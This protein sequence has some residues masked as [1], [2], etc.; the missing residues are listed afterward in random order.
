[1]VAITSF[2]ASENNLVR[3]GT[4]LGAKDP[5]VRR[6]RD[7]FT[8]AALMPALDPRRCAPPSAAHGRG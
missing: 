2:W 7:F 5:I 4:V 6:C 8:E 3:A 1:M